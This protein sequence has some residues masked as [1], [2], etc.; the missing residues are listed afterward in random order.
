VE[1]LQHHAEGV[2]AVLGAVWTLISVVNGMLNNPEV[3][4]AWGKLLDA[5]SY[6]ARKDAHGSVKVPFVLSKAP[7]GP[8]PIPADASNR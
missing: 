2:V 7:A 8:P 1:Q 3:K 5:V 4:T 6:I